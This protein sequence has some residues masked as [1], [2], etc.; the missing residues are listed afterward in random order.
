V[1]RKFELLPAL[2]ERGDGLGVRHPLERGRD[3]AL[4]PGDARLVDAVGEKL[5]VIAAF[6]QER[7]E[8]V[9]EE[10]LGEIRVVVQVRERELGLHHP[11]FC[12]VPAGVAVLSAER[13]PERVDL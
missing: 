10:G 3:E 8:N 5:Q 4:E 13:R 7:R 11:E 9:L 1:H 2:F 6:G 12:K